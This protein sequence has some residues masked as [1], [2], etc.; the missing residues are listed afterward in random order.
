MA[1]LKAIP[2]HQP[3]PFHGNNEWVISIS[4]LVIPCFIGILEHEKTTKQPIRISIKC[5]ALLSQGL[6][7]GFNYLCYADLIAKVTAHIDQ[8]HIRLVENLAES[9]S[10]LCFEHENVYR[11]FVSVEKIAVYAHVASVGVEIDR[12][13]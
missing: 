8:G 3:N 6:T 10:Q 7:Q 13:R 1:H 12:F 9:I 5:Y 11:V 2:Q 4:D